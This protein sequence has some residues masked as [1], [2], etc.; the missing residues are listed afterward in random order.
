MRTELI[1]KINEIKEK[2]ADG[3]TFTDLSDD[4]LSDEFYKEFEIEFD[5]EDETEG[6]GFEKEL[7]KSLN[8]DER[9]SKFSNKF[10]DRGCWNSNYYNV[11]VDNATYDKYKGNY[12]DWLIYK[13]GYDL[14]K[15]KVFYIDENSNLCIAWQEEV[16]GPY[17]DTFVY[18]IIE[19]LEPDVE[20]E[21]IANLA[22]NGIDFETYIDKEVLLSKEIE[23][24]LFEKNMI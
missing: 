4:A 18:D 11:F 1:N 22:N 8:D 21:R 9:I 5:E 3:K 19:V 20:I 10:L 17:D 16:N 12:E 14:G 13:I 2:V 23:E 6:F 24:I 7:E 15:N